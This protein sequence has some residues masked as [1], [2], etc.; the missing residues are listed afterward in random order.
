MQTGMKFELLR[1]IL[2][3]M[4]SVLVAYSGGVD[5]TFLA[6]IA[7]EELGSCALAI[8]VSGCIFPSDEHVEAE[9]TAQELGLTHQIIELDF[10]QY[11]DFCSN[12]PD[13]CYH[14]RMVIFD[15]L[16]KIAIEKGLKWIIDGTNYDD[17]TDYRPGLKAAKE[18]GVRS[19]LIEAKLS[20]KEI[21]S[22]SRQMGLQT[23][24]KPASP[25]LA[26]RIPYNTLI[27]QEILQLIDKGEQFMRGLGFS[28]LRLRH[29]GNIARIEV[30]EQEID[31]LLRKE[32]R[33]KI[34]REFKSM[35]YK[36]ITLD[37]AG[38]CTGSL[39]IGLNKN[40]IEVQT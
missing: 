34:V 29:H 23:W 13:R 10:L 16:K 37:L 8:F 21:R 9:K 30:D 32:V 6:A 15:K 27:T 36:Y 35:G 1:H 40:V 17:L 2:K 38:Y 24:N 19:P 18:S 14:C 20:K 11:P 5:S 28:Q 33:Q 12:P 26:S 7:K 39:N 4:S 31:L 3:E 22:L 25:C